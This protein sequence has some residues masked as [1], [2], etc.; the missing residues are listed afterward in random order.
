MGSWVFP[1]FLSSTPDLGVFVFGSSESGSRRTEPPAESDDQSFSSSAQRGDERPNSIFIGLEPLKNVR[2]T[3]WRCLS[4]KGATT[5]RKSLITNISSMGDGNNPTLSR[6][7]FKK[8]SKIRW[9]IE[10]N[11]IYY[12]YKVRRKE[13]LIYERRP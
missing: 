2:R 10:I 5:Q 13:D 6:T 4:F 3:P 12:L 1:S 7:I 8:L 11:F 9:Q